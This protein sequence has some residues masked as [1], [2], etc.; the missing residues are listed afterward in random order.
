MTNLKK[1]FFVCV[2]SLFVIIPNF[3]QAASIA[4]VIAITGG[5]TFERAGTSTDL[6][7][8]ADLHVNDVIRTNANG[9]VQFIFN[10]ESIVNIGNNSTFIVEDYS[11]DVKKSFKANLAVGFA[12]FVSGEIV[13]N[14]PEAFSVKTPEATVGI[15]GTT[16]AIMTHNGTTDVATESSLRQQ[17]VVVGTV[18]IP[19]GQIG[20]FGINGEVKSHPTFMT[21]AQREFI[22]DSSSIEQLVISTNVV[23]WQNLRPNEFSEITRADTLGDNN[24]IV[25]WCKPSKCQWSRRHGH[26]YI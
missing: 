4:K 7:L 8:K 13:E 26:W 9:K 6:A 10:D 24:L 16:L 15:R 3:A 2:L 23:G 14:N 25:P 12:R 21:P 17:S 19:V 5:V 11:N 1:L 18:I 22:L 20:S